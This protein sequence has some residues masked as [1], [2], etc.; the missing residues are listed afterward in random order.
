[1]KLKTNNALLDFLLRIWKSRIVYKKNKQVVPP[2]TVSDNEWQRVPTNY[3][4]WHNEWQW[5]MTG[6][7]EW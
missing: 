6:D 1:M 5:V 7:S 2:V 3:N 4:E